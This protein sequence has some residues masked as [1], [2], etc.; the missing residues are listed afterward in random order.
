MGLASGSSVRKALQPLLANED[1][2]ERHG[3]LKV[4]DPFFA[5]W[6]RADGPGLG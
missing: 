5:A 3:A 2:V 6:L 4:A 1:V